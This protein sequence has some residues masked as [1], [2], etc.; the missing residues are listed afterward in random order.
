MDDFTRK[1]IDRIYD[2][3]NKAS[4]VCLG[5]ASKEVSAVDGE[6]GRITWSIRDNDDID[7]DAIDY[8]QKWETPCP[9]RSDK[10]HCNCWY[11]DEQCCACGDKMDTT[12]T[13]EEKK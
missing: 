2:I 5:T 8:E 6:V 9:K 3:L 10:K 11:D 7:N 4:I 12:K 13:K 1:V